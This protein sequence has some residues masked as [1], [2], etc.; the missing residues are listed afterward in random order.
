VEFKLSP[1]LVGLL[2]A[3]LPGFAAAWVFYAFTAHKKAEPFERTVQAVIFTVFTMMFVE[4]AKKPVKGW[5]IT[6]GSRYV[7]LSEWDDQKSTLFLGMILGLTVG[8]VASWFA[9]NSLIHRCCSW[10]R[11]TKRT[12]YASEWYSVFHRAKESFVYLN[13]K[14]GRRLFGWAEQYPDDPKEGHFV[15]TDVSVPTEEG[16][17]PRELIARM[18]IPVDLIETVEFEKPNA[19]K[20]GIFRQIWRFLKKTWDQIRQVSKEIWQ[21]LQ[22]WRNKAD[23]K[24]KTDAAEPIGTTG[25]LIGG[26]EGPGRLQPSK[27]EA[28]RSGAETGVQ[29]AAEVA[30]AETVNNDGQAKT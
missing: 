17:E 23:D 12:S 22:T 2:Y 18:L 27:A 13:Y 6:L 11:I 9:N 28:D 14:D 30:A 21:F 1:E 19:I 10:L 7:A 16:F 24:T 26:D 3:L 29:A 20:V 25:Y 5:L 4:V 8:L 15:L